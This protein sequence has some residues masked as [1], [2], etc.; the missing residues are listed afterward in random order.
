M[1]ELVRAF[2]SNC[3]RRLGDIREII[4]GTSGT[5]VHNNPPHYT[6]KCHP[7]EEYVAEPRKEEE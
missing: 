5:W 4:Q 1:D 3:Y 6:L 7:F 2:C